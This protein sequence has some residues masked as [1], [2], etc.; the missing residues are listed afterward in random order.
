M[1]KK[2]LQFLRNVVSIVRGNGDSWR[3]ILLLAEPPTGDIS[4]SSTQRAQHSVR[5][6]C[7]SLMQSYYYYYYYLIELQMCFYPVAVVLQYDTN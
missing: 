4:S 5:A 6:L 3:Q 7:F 1:L 2:Q